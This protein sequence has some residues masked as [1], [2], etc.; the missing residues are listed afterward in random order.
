MENR[1]EAVRRLPVFVV[2]SGERGGGHELAVGLKLLEKLGECQA[3]ELVAGD[4]HAL[5][6]LVGGCD[7]VIGNGDAEVHRCVTT[8]ALCDEPAPRQPFPLRGCRRRGIARSLCGT[9]RSL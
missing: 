1:Y 6:K 3:K 9:P 5:G 8:L 4:S 7:E 2:V